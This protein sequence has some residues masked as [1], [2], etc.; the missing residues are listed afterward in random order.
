MR[1]TTALGAAW[2]AGSEAGVLPGEE[3]FTALYRC[4][5]FEASPGAEDWRETRYRAWKRSVAAVIA[6]A[7]DA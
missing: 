4:E 7:G 5:R 2:L 1:E 3:G 6:Q